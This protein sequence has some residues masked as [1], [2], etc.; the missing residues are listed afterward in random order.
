MYASPFLLVFQF[1]AIELLL[2]QLLLHLLSSRPAFY[3]FALFFF[4]SL[5]TFVSTFMGLFQKCYFKSYL[6]ILIPEVPWPLS[7]LHPPSL[8]PSFVVLTLRSE[9]ITHRCDRRVQETE[10]LPGQDS[11][12]RCLADGRAQLAFQKHWKERCRECW[13]SPLEKFWRA[14]KRKKMIPCLSLLIT[15]VTFIHLTTCRKY[16]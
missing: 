14:G 16:G 5:V 4:F 2:L 13:G 9:E 11:G 10:P 15:E 8:A 7:H 3:T 1:V 12:S 6:H